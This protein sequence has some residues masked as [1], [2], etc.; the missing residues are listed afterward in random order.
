MAAFFFFAQNAFG[1][2]FFAKCLRGAYLRRMPLG[3]FF[4]K[5]P[6]GRL[7]AQNI[8]GEHPMNFRPMQCFG[9]LPCSASGQSR[10]AAEGQHKRA[11]EQK[12]TARTHKKEHPT[13][14]NKVAVPKKIVGTKIIAHR[15]KKS[16]KVHKIKRDRR[17]V[18][19]RGFYVG[20]FRY[21]G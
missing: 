20:N 5:M 9:F 10:C 12:G 6:S 7:F 18:G 17:T 1:V 19:K 15:Y 3:C 21:T 11:S 13:K 14:K 8:F 2:F 4:R 16:A